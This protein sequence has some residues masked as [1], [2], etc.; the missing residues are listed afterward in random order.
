MVYRSAETVDVASTLERTLSGTLNRAADELG[1]VTVA[2]LLTEGRQ[3]EVTYLW[4]RSGSTHDHR[5][6]DAPEYLAKAVVSQK[7][8]VDAEVQ[9]VQ[10]LRQSIVPDAQSFLLHHSRIRQSVATTA[11]GFPEPAVADR[12]IPGAVTERL[13]LVGLATWSL[14]EI[15]RLRADLKT[16][17]GRLAGRKLVE[18][19]KGIIQAERGLSE[20]QAYAFLRGSSRRRRIPLRELAE[21]VLR[22]R[23]GGPDLA[24]LSATAT[25]Q[26]GQR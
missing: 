15:A 9:L 16:V 13:E 25:I 4:N 21:E 18:R 7:G 24:P 6:L 17:N 2:V 23:T 5:V 12:Q 22:S 8:P 11:F 14:R 26:P 19:A 20:E 3:V 10:L 1:A